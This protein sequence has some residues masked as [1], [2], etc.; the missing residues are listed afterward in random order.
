MDCGVEL[1]SNNPWRGWIS[2]AGFL[3]NLHLRES[4]GDY[5]E[6]ELG[7]EL[8]CP[9]DVIFAVRNYFIWRA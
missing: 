7:E 1:T 5:K 4:N 3:M 9:L 6:V 8:L 2:C